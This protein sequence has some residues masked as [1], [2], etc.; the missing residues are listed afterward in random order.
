M[1]L[2][3][4]KNGTSVLL[5]HAPWDHPREFERITRNIHL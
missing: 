1:N 2:W 5:G 4:K 3:K